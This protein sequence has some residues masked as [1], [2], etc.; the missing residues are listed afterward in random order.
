MLA[1]AIIASCNCKAFLQLASQVLSSIY[2]AKT[3]TKCMHD[4]KPFNTAVKTPST[5]YYSL[6]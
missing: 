2:V 6:P 3:V 4:I 1:I 5:N